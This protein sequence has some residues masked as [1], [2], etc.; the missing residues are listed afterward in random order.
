MNRTIGRAYEALALLGSHPSGLTLKEITQSLQIPKSS[1]FD[2]VQTLL[3]LKLTAISKA[4][5]K[6]YVLGSE[7]FSLG[8]LYVSNLNVTDVYEQYLIPLADE[9]HRNAFVAV[10]DELE[11][12]YI[13]KY[14]GV[15]AK[16]ATCNLGTRSDLYS[17]ALGKVLLSYLPEDVRDRTIDRIE[18]KRHT[19]YTI[20]SKEALKKEC[21]KVRNRGY[22]TD[23]REREP[24][25]LCFSC[26]IFDYT[27][28]VV[29]AVSV[30]DIYYEGMDRAVIVDKLKA[31]ALNISKAL[32]YSKDQ[33]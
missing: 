1:A 11:I 3:G 12:V 5:D 7:I 21:I 16:L 15:G 31:C 13:Y 25:M 4:N 29:A 18:F 23:N 30:S 14:V 22:A 28:N 26:P 20:M 6:K 9:L 27:G 8:M 19:E 2:I 17:T 33:F 32:G 24:H 10:L